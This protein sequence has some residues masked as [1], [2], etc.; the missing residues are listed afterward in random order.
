M[1]IV[2]IARRIKLTDER[3][4]KIKNL[5]TKV[6]W[7]PI[8]RYLFLNSLKLNMLAVV[9]FKVAEKA[10]GDV[11]PAIAILAVLN[12]AP[13]VFYIALRRNK[14]S[15]DTETTKNSIGSIY[16]GKNLASE[17]RNALVYHP[18]A[19]FLRRLIFVVIT[20]FKFDQPQIQMLA[21]HVLTVLMI[22]V[23]VYNPRAYQSRSQKIIEVGSEIFMHFTS[24]C[25]SQFCVRNYDSAY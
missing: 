7:N 14:D 21:H 13:L 23:L 22:A 19:F 17:G 2:F 16:A 20:V 1:I 12:G 6:F 24:I 11:A 5:R 9:V 3:K 8:V 15:L 25:M 18:W 10:I 4:K